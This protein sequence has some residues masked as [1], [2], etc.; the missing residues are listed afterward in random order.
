MEADAGVLTVRYQ[1]GER[2]YEIKHTSLSQ[3]TVRSDHSLKYVPTT[4]MKS[5]PQTQNT[6]IHPTTLSNRMLQALFSNAESPFLPRTVTNTSPESHV[7]EQC[8]LG[9]SVGLKVWAD[10]A[11]TVV[12]STGGWMVKM[13]LERRLR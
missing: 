9:C 2:A 10:C 12:M 13:M 5:P 8:H 6:S 1:H 7:Y 3:I 4:T 11:V